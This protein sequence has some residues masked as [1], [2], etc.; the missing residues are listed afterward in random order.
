M[1]KCVKFT[2]CMRSIG[3]NLF[4]LLKTWP[5]GCVGGHVH[6]D[7]I[8]AWIALTSVARRYPF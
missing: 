3:V 1:H 7:I 5:E 6:N 4:L 8:K 2:I